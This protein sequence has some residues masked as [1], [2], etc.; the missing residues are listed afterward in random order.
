MVLIGSFLAWYRL[1]TGTQAGAELDV[2]GRMWDDTFPP[3]ESLLSLLAWLARVHAGPLLAVP[4]GGDHWGSIATALVCLV[5]VGVLIR[6]GRYRLLVLCSAPFA[7]NLI[8]A[9]MRRFP[10]GGHMRL[11]M[12]LA[13]LVCI[14]AAIGATAV[15]HWPRWNRSTPRPPRPEEA[16]RG[17]PLTWP[18]AAAIVGAADAGSAIDGP[19]FLHA[20]QRAAGDPQTGFRRLVLGQHGTGPR[21]GLHLRGPEADLCAAGRRLGELRLAAVPLQRADLLAAAGPRPEATT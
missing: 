21:S 3:R 8:A 7:L 11:A 2:M 10:Y 4:V 19:R 18:V 6:Q 1:A 9:A 15:L 17:E 13:P 16:C 14:L 12:H 5:A 20:G